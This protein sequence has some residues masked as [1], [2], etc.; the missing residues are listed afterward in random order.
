MREL[1]SSKVAQAT[2]I[3]R[4]AI[5]DKTWTAEL[6][7]ERKLA[8]QLRISRAS[9]RKALEVLTKEGLLAPGERSKKR[10][11]IQTGDWQKNQGINRVVFL[12]QNPAHDT[13]PKVLEQFAQLSYYLS[14]A[15]FEVEFESS[16]VFGFNRVSSDVM[17][18]LVSKHD[19]AHW[20]LHQ[21]PEHVQWW[22]SE[23]KINATVFGS[24]FSGV[25]LPYVDVD[26]GGSA[27]HATGH[28]L[29]RGHRRFGL[30]RFRSQLAG[31]DCAFRGMVD[32]LMSHRERHMLEVPQVLTHNFSVERLKRSLD[33]V[34]AEP[35]PP[36]A[37][38]VVNFHHLITVMTHLPSIGFPI[39]DKVSVISLIHDQ[40][41]ESF[42]PKPTCYS[43]GDHLI[44]RL[45][46]LVLGRVSGSSAEEDNLLIPEL[47]DGKSVKSVEV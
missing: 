4:A 27:R 43:V 16:E 37:L 1:P 2:D 5:C 17:E 24:I 29:A 21:C 26:F 34:F 7:S 46:Q 28:L 10:E 40:M 13:S 35:N 38:I 15:G 31:D 33:L 39:P 19:R 20:I 45:V 41:L 14:K 32:A 6:P 22:F 3:I 42:S 36:T 11:I 30:V 25:E 9:V 12:T 8:E 18:Q 44:K 47:I 23:K